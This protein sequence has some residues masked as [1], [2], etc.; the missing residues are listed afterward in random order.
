[1]NQS[2]LVD[3]ILVVSLALYGLDGYRR[4]FIFL[5]LEFLGLFVTFYLGLV[6][7]DPVGQFL[8]G[9][10]AFPEALIK[11]VGFL[12]V[13]LIA[14]LAYSGLTS[15]LYR[16]IPDLIRDSLPNKIA[17]TFPSILKGMVMLAI[18]LTL[19]VVLPVET[20][21]RPSINQSYLGSR[22]VKAIQTY[23]QLALK[24]FDQEITNTLTFLTN[25]PLR[26]NQIQEPGEFKKLPFNGI[27][28][29]VD[30]EAEDQ[31]L[32]LVN[33]ERAKLGLKPL[34]ADPALQVVARAHARDM[35]MRGYFAHDNPDGEDPFDRMAKAGVTYI[36]AG[37]NLALAPT[38]DLAHLGLMNSPK[39][40]D[41]ILFEEFGRLGVGV[42]DG[43]LYGK[44]FVQEFRN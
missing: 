27:D 17:G 33:K 9:L 4:G 5:A 10:V 15:L 44:M 36:T 28:G 19:L 29:K 23:E 24:R 39:H 21:L 35:F 30:S 40:R 2:F 34:A 18:I 32:A 16:F 26:L 8:H 7:A 25:T 12:V 22:M 38:T 41:N 6:L 42:I 3:L 43:G 11:V 37:E 13:W 20:S 31:M 1:M 14:Q